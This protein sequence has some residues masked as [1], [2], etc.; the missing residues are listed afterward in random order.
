MDVSVR[1]ITPTDYHQTIAVIKRSIS[2]SLSKVYPQKLIDEFCK[3]YTLEN[4]GEKAKE[5]EY[6]IAEEK[7][8][9]TIVGIIALKEN[10]LRTFFV[11]PNFQGKG[12]GRKLYNHIESIAK[13][14][15]IKK[16]ILKGS[17]IGEL[18]YLKFGFKKVKSVEKE[19]EG[20]TYCDAYMEKELE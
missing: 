7:Q 16:I 6:F 3:K 5:I 9:K 2:G 12:I 18:V 11:D 19:R 1:E 15:N 17:P 8:T 4:F 14:R 20:I 10:E 13:E